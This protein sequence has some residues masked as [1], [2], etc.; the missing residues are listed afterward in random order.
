LGLKNGG[1]KE[2][3]ELFR[4]AEEKFKLVFYENSSTS[5][6]NRKGSKGAVKAPSGSKMLKDP[7]FSTIVDEVV[8]EV[9]IEGGYKKPTYEDIFVVK[10]FYFPYSM[11][12]WAKR[13]YRIAYLETELTEEECLELTIETVGL[14]TWE[15][16]TPSEQEDALQRRLW[17]PG[18]Q[19]EFD[20][21]REEEYLRKNPALFKR[22]QRYKKK[23]KMG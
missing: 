2:T 8:G 16:M 13:K 20:K 17:L 7:L 9:K 11:Y 15:D 18:Q 21:H 10:L 22:Y 14:G 23:E 6:S 3:L 5:N 19:E 4:R 1:T 12:T